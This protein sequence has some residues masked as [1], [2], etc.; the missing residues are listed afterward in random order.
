MLF[1]NIYSYDPD[2]RDKIIARRLEKGLMFPKG[3]KVLGEWSA[4]GGSMGVI[5]C[6]TD[7]PKALAQASLAWSDLLKSDIFP[8]LKT[9]DVLSLAKK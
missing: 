2:K 8:V 9:E 4:I 7:D 6:E 1:I 3:I 5:V